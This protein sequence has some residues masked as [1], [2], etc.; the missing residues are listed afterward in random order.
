MCQQSPRAGQLQAPWATVQILPSWVE[1]ST[2]IM[3]GSPGLRA[4]S[5]RLLDH[6]LEDLPDGF[7]AAHYASDLLRNEK[8]GEGDLHVVSVEPATMGGEIDGV[9]LFHECVV[10]FYEPSEE[11]FDIED[12]RVTVRTGV[13]NFVV[14]LAVHTPWAT[15]QI[16]P[17]WVEDSTRI[18][19]DA[20]VPM[21]GLQQRGPRR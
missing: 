7:H 21:A 8:R 18:M 16:L 15:V 10:L 17:S 1:D 14:H 11:P 9:V 4:S 13:W 5:C 19:I 20:H 12:Q 3:M 6:L 2:R